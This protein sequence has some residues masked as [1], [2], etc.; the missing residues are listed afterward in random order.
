VTDDSSKAAQSAK[1]VQNGADQAR[2][3]LK[4]DRA[5]PKRGRLKRVLLK[6]LFSLGLTIL[7]L[8]AGAA[9]IIHIGMIPS[10]L[11]S[12]SLPDRQTSMFGDIDRHVGAWH[13][14]NHRL[15]HRRACFRVVYR[16]NSYGALDSEREKKSDK[17]RVIVLGDSFATGHGVTAKDR[18]SDRLEKL[19][20][21]EHLNFGVGGTG[22]TQYYMVYKTKARAFDHDRV[23]VSILPAN[24]FFDDKPVKWRYRPYWHGSYPNYTLRYS[25]ESPEVSPNHPPSG[26]KGL[27]Y[28][29]ILGTYSYFYN[30][31][32]WIYGAYRLM[33]SRQAHADYSGYFDFKKDE[34]DR[35][36]YSL[37]KIHALVPKG[38][39][40]VMIIPRYMDFQ[41]YKKAGKK[42][43]LGEALQKV[44]DKV[45]FKLVDMLP[46]MAKAYP[47]R[48]FKLFLGCDGHWSP[49][50][51][52][53]AAKTLVRELYSK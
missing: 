8:E 18:F 25:L 53:F 5:K 41:R 50:G 46:R 12:Y 38:R 7:L 49:L 33:R 32:D 14:P 45:G 30:A 4:I 39:L 27:T 52:D 35:L 2:D 43:P 13:P 23:L 28:H 40:A 26:K 42:S 47:D 34:F 29:D 17:P 21:L 31:A 44:A 1:T 10:R 3:T 24:D 6:T 51:H 22:P 20:G 37:E 11:P 48:E 36:R 15:E 19:T 9:L 16:S